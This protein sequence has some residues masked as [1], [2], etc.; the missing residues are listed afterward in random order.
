ML[1]INELA[2]N[3]KLVIFPDQNTVVVK[4]AKTCTMKTTNSVSFILFPLFASALPEPD[5][6]LHLHLA[7]E[8]EKGILAVIKLIIV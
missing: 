8:G 1:T 6:H 4:L 2:G 5:T 7:P 3:R